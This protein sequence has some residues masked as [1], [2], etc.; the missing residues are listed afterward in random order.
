MRIIGFGFTKIYAEKKLDLS[1]FNIN[2]HIEFINLEK[3]KANILKDAEAYKLIFKYNLEYV[4]KEQEKEEKQAEVSFEGFL[5]V[6]LNK[7]ESKNF[8]KSWKKKEI[9]QEN[10]TPLYNFILKKCSSKSVFLQDEIN[11]PS[12]YLKFPQLQPSK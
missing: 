1:Q 12:P 5:M 9:P 8:S 3:E 4:K 7:E 10:I 11:L 2:N 6:S